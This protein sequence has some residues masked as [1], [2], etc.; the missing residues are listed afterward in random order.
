MLVS[1]SEIVDEDNTHR[2]KICSICKSNIDPHLMLTFR[3][4]LFCIKSHKFDEKAKIKIGTVEKSHILLEASL[5]L[6][7]GSSILGIC[8][9]A[10]AK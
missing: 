10:S 4:F 9:I 1:L 8:A 7:E 3:V 5:W 2:A 6:N